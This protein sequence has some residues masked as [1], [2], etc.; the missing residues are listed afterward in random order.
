MSLLEVLVQTPLSEAAGWT[1]I[2]FFWE[3]AAI[4]AV[5]AV[6]LA[7]VR[8]PGIRYIAG[9]IALLAMLACFIAMFFHFLPELS[10]ERVGSAK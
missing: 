4:A 2:H 9:C 3:G 6:L 5:F 7:L 1:L 10:A 8:S